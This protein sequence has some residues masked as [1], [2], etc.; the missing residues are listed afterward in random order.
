MISS[1]FNTAAQQNKEPLVTIGVPT[2][3]RPKGL[4]RSLDHILLQT[5]SNLEIIISDNCSTDDTVQQIIKEYAEKDNRIKPFRQKEN[6]GLEANF[7]FVFSKAS[8][9]Y[10]IWMSDDDYFDS[11]YI[12]ECIKEL[13][14][15]PEYVLC[16][17][18][19]HYYTGS[20]FLFTEKMFFVNQKSPFLRLFTYFSNVDKNGSF[21]GVFRNRL[22]QEKPIG[23]H[24]GCDWSFM[25]KLAILGKLTYTTKTSYHRSAEGNS[26]TKKKMINKFG[27]NKL[28]ALFFETYSAYTIATNIFND[29]TVARSFSYLQKKVITTIIFFQINYKLLMKFIKKKLSVS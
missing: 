20:H 21:Y 16:S 6:I 26:E 27:F 13:S 10:F 29:T 24:I 23:L 2:Y 18:V 4:V 19:A 17:G 1:A 22:L 15:N 7:N 12:E 5:Y 9:D 28:Q 25:A 11:N 14:Q 3:N 8:A